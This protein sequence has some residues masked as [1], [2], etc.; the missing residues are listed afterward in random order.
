MY[1]V[2]F[3]SGALCALGG[4]MEVYGMNHR[5]VHN[6][7]VSTSFA[8]IGLI[9]ALISNYNPWGVLVTAIILSGISTGGA[10]IDRSTDIP[11]EIAS[12]IRGCIT[13]FISAKIAFQYRIKIT[14]EKKHGA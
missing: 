2:L 4:M 5:Y 7:Y 1:L 11:V 10:A 12:I 8:W 6:M 13:L 3:L 14:K 9:A